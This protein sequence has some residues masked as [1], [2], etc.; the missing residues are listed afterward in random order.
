[1]RPK[2][3][4]LSA[5]LSAYFEAALEQA[6]AVCGLSAS[7]AVERYLVG[8]LCDFARPD[9]QV[10]AS[11]D[12]PLTFL[13]RDAL[14]AAGGERFTRLRRLGDEV[15]YAL[16]FFG[17]SL[18][19]HGADRRYVTG[20]GRSAY[21]H[22]AAMLRAAHGSPAAPAVLGEL[23]HKYEGCVAVLSEVAD[24]SLAAGARNDAA[25]LRVYERWCVTRSEGLAQKLGELGL[26]PMRPHKPTRQ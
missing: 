12:R 16:G 21:E 2:D 14:A 10:A 26:L 13:L 24:E 6:M 20:V 25:V 1:M 8:L 19:R 18:T 23:A 11:L 4:S 7:Q 9:W 5:D 17:Q 22:A 15:L 3:F